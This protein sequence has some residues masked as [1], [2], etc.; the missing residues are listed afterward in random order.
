MLKHT[1]TRPLKRPPLTLSE[2]PCR[3]IILDIVFGK[4]IHLS[5]CPMSIKNQPNS[6]EV[7]AVQGMPLVK[8][9]PTAE[10]S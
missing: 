2:Q 4:L 7:N 8:Q 1:Q 9:P 5:D 3:R 6:E 10:E